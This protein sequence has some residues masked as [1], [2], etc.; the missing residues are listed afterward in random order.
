MAL[1]ADVTPQ[2][3]EICRTVGFAAHLSKPVDTQLLLRTLAELTDDTEASTAMPTVSYE[4]AG[5][6]AFLTEAEA[7]PAIDLRRLASLAELDQGDG[8]LAGLIDDFLTDLEAMQ[9][10]LER[11]AVER[12]VRAFRD[13]AHALRSSAAHVGATGLFDLCLSWRELDDHALLMRAPVELRRLHS[14]AGRVAAAMHAFY[15]E[16]ELRLAR[17][18]GGHTGTVRRL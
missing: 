15:N 2:T 12:D 17:P 18:A 4:C 8:F 9:A 14:E 11:A 16:W 5:T 13:H 6:C 1:S 3:R 10:D 7:A